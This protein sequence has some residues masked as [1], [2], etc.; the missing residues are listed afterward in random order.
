MRRIL[1]AAAAATVTAQR[2]QWA[3]HSSGY[4]HNR[5]QQGNAEQGCQKQ[6]RRGA[7][8][9][10]GLSPALSHCPSCVVLTPV[11]LGHTVSAM[12]MTRNTTHSREQ[13]QRTYRH[14]CMAAVHIIKTSG[15]WRK[16][17]NKL[18]LVWLTTTRCPG[19]LTT[20]TLHRFV[21]G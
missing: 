21:Y 3:T 7:L 10:V 11:L 4:L 8:P 14:A 15:M 9:W 12:Q 16:N 2:A 13:E 18:K 1:Q 19:Q 20:P 5:L 17:I 6:R